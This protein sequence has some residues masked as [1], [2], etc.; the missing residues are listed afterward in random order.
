MQATGSKPDH[1]RTMRKTTWFRC[2]ISLAALAMVSGCTKVLLARGQTYSLTTIGIVQIEI[3]AETKGASLVSRS[4]LGVGWDQLPRGSGFLGW[5]NATWVVVEPSECQ[6]VIM[7]S[8]TRQLIAAK[9]V[10]RHWEGDTLCLV[11][12]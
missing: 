2:A 6:I 11:E 9:E 5:S 8:D 10:V 12:K 7:V 3:P 1:H 4:A